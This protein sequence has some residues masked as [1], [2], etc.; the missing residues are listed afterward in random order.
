MTL[1]VTLKNKIVKFKDAQGN[2]GRTV[3]PQ[4]DRKYIHTGELYIFRFK[5]DKSEEVI[6]TYAAG[7]WH[8]FYF[9]ELEDK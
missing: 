2:T 3:G 6:K 1:V 7:M 9:E 8:D 4:H 5:E